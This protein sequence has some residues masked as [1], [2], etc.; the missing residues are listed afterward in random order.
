VITVAGEITDDKAGP[1]AA[2][3]Q[4]IARLIDQAGAKKVAALVI[5]SICRAGR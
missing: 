5:G 4:R 2:G 1:G 3:G